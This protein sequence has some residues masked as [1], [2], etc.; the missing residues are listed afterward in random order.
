MKRTRSED[1]KLSR[2]LTAMRGHRRSR[3]RP[4]S[5]LVASK[6][7]GEEEETG[8]ARWVVDD[9][10]DGSSD[11]KAELIASVKREH[12][13]RDG[14]ERGL[15]KVDLDAAEAA[16]PAGAVEELAGGQRAGR[17]ARRESS[18]RAAGRRSVS[19]GPAIGKRVA[20]ALRSPA[21]PERG[22]S[23]A[24][25][26]A[27]LRSLGKC[28]RF[29]KLRDSMKV[30]APQAGRVPHRTSSETGAA[31]IGSKAANVS[32]KDLLH[33]YQLEALGE[34]RN[35][36][37]D[38]FRLSED[39]PLSARSLEPLELSE[40]E[41]FD[42][43]R[44]SSQKDLTTGITYT[45]RSG[46]SSDYPG[47][48]RLPA[49]I[50]IHICSYLGNAADL[51]SVMQTCL[52]LYILG[53]YDGLWRELCFREGSPVHFLDPTP[54]MGTNRPA[55]VPNLPWRVLYRDWVHGI[56]FDAITD[57]GEY[58]LE[59]LIKSREGTW[60]GCCYATIT[61]DVGLKD[62]ADVERYT[63]VLERIRHPQ[64]ARVF[65]HD[66]RIESS[67]PATTLVYE[68]IGYDYLW[69]R[70]YFDHVAVHPPS[71]HDIQSMVRQVVS[72]MEVILDAF[73]S[74]DASASPMVNPCW[75]SFIFLVDE[76][77]SVK[78]TL[79]WHEIMQQPIPD[80]RKLLFAAPNVFLDEEL[81]C[82]RTVSWSLGVLLYSVLCL[83]FPVDL[84]DTRNLVQLIFAIVANQCDFTGREWKHVSLDAKDLIRSLLR[85]DVRL[86]PTMKEVLQHPWL[87][88]PAPKR[89]LAAYADV[90]ASS[91]Y[92]YWVNGETS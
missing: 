46:K 11:E 38:H 7:G 72:G 3:S 43:M 92:R 81:D 1:S 40:L 89:P 58:F 56:T 54:Q 59:N 23:S 36:V 15:A 82:E 35:E 66:M 80:Y 33:L 9:G 45:P 70:S 78:L 41:E 47:L 28:Q 13:D 73:S 83:R 37:R 2:A 31:L 21:I 49:E 86:R 10:D 8:E 39:G 30:C 85:K 32:Q 44:I 29:V 71:E 5:F 74:A 87:T 17:V 65:T 69:G 53:C 42:C 91:I 27:Q 67:M 88:K 64:V 19:L 76:M 16:G 22:G 61:Y 79:F 48:L 34:G 50:I 25:L 62:L 20:A 60:R 26:E 14:E 4:G 75:P 77:S 84:R 57:H 68:H 18:G 6:G 24:Q 12:S 55:G 51:C 90:R 52:A 63:A